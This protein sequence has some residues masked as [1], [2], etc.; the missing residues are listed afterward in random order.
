MKKI[1][2]SAC[3]AIALISVVMAQDKKD[4]VK[5]SYREVGSIMPPMRVIDTLKHEYSA[6][7]FDNKKHFFLFLFNPTCGHCIQMAKLVSDNKEVFKDNHVLFLAGPAMMP[8]LASFYQ[9]S[10]INMHSDI[11]VGID[12][13]STVDRLYMYQT[14]PQ[15]NI[16]DKNR[17]LVKIM[18]GDVA[19]DSLKR[20]IP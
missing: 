16:Y 7:D 4:E 14:L 20:Y 13:A 3:A 18:Y 10:G 9:A 19:L 12:S 1:F 11:K 17:K 15:I 6:S 5:V 2:L 8:Y